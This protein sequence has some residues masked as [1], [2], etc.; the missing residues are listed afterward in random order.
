LQVVDF[1]FGTPRRGAT[2]VRAGERAIG[3]LVDDLR[4]DPPGRLL[5]VISDDIVSPLH[6]EPLLRRLRRARLRAE[7]ITFPHGERNKSR[8]TKQRLEDAMLAAGA[9]RDSAVIAVG[10]GVTGDL[11]GFVAATWHRGVPV[12]QVPTTLLAMVDSALGGKT[13]VNLPGGKN[14]VGSFHRPAA[15][16]ADVGTL[17]TLPERHYVEGFAEAVKSAVIGDA[18]LFRWIEENSAALLARDGAALVHLVACCLSIKGRIVARDERERGRRAVLNFGHTVA[19]AL[20]T[21]TGYRMAHGRAVAVGMTVEARLACRV[22]GFPATHARRL[23]TLLAVLG[24]PTAPPRRL[25]AEALVGATRLDKK[26]RAGEV[27]YALPRALGR[28]LPAPGFTVPV[29][30]RLLRS[31]LE[32]PLD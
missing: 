3:A 8:R 12:I 27:R 26:N 32:G 21:A 17:A 29:N 9:G 2:R 14:L 20:E 30:A 13:A 22:T 31:A 7:L 10:G 11:A 4:A 6:A 28:M 24:L 19:H 15:V 25:D 23:E 18:K 1:T 5:L 16:Y